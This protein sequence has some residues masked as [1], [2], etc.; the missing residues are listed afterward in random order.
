MPLAESLGQ[1]KHSVEK[2]TFRYRII[3]TCDK[4]TKPQTFYGI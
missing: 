1:K 3:D 4:T 2:D